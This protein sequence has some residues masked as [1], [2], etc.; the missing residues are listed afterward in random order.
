MSSQ[1][2]RRR[3]DWPCLLV[4]L[5][6]VLGLAIGVY[7]LLDWAD[8]QTPWVFRVVIVLVSTSIAYRMGRAV[9]G[10]RPP[11]SGT[12]WIAFGFAVVAAGLAIYFGAVRPA[13]RDRDKAEQA[14]ERDESF[15]RLLSDGRAIADNLEA[16]VRDTPE[17]AEGVTATVELRRRHVDALTQSIA[18]M[19]RYKSGLERFTPDQRQELHVE[20]TR[21]T[22]ATKAAREKL[23]R[24][25]G[26]QE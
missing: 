7:L 9:A 2:P 3:G 17:P 14:K 8:D 20:F 21:M 26:K 25:K 13:M 10:K 15:A 4:A 1:A 18:W 5:G 11:G 12:N 24:L 23:G 16:V 6:L 22:E 19:D